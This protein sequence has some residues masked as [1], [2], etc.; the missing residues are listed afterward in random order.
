MMLKDNNN[1]AKKALIIG[2]GAAGFFAA[3]NLARLRPDL[4]VILVEK[5]GKLLSKVKVSG[6]GR[7]NVTHACFEIGELVKRY[8]RGASLL[9]KT[10]HQ[11]NP[12]HTIEWFKERG[13]ALKAEA[14]GRMFPVTNQSQTI[15][16]CLLKEADDYQVKTWMHREVVSLKQVT[17]GSWKVLFKSGEEVEAAVVCV[18]CGGFSKREQFYW[19]EELGLPI[20]TP[21]PSLFTFNL[22]EHPIVALMGVSVSQAKVK[23]AG[24]KIETEGPLLVTHWG[25]SGPAVLKASAWGA[26]ILAEKQWQFQANVNWIG[27][28]NEQ[29][30]YDYLQELRSSLNTQKI[31]GKNPFGIPNRLWD[32]FLQQCGISDSLKWADLPAKSQR[33]LC[34]ML[35]NQEFQV[36][37]KTTFKE[38]FVTA[39][40]VELSAIDSN[41]ME[42]KKWKGL[43][44][45]GEIMDVDGV[46][47]GFNFQHAWTSS[48]IA[49]RHMSLK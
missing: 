12:T 37:G 32:F 8:P 2:G 35:T 47:G 22:P 19:L 34:M 41:S 6:G 31:Y 46:T 42:S 38:E 24:T 28:Y 30:C 15:I 7:C 36:R 20:E 26:R 43:F 25:L 11:F 39:G 48:W 49:A 13:V 33:K 1:E 40:G 27:D 10:L 23:I 44:F 17:D 14:D 21:V 9:K 29:T 18:A 45:A 3:V 5:T 4:Q 16:D